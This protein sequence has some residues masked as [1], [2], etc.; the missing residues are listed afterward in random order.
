MYVDFPSTGGAFGICIGPHIT[1]ACITGTTV[2]TAAPTPTGLDNRVRVRV[3]V[4]V[5]PGRGADSAQPGFCD[6]YP[7]WQQLP[8]QRLYIHTLGI[9]LSGI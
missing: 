7:I 6:Q 8:T 1:A 9:Y 2:A 4:A 5:G 3:R